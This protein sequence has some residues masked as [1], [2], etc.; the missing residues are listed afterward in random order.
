M[1]FFDICLVFFFSNFLLVSFLFWAITFLG[2]F[3]YEKKE[4]LNQ[5]EFYEC[6]F[7]SINNINF[8]LN[9]GIFITMVFVILYDVEI[10]FL[11]PFLLNNLSLDFFN[12]LNILFLYLCIL[13]TFIID[14]YSGTIKWE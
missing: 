9:L 4:N 13:Y 3:F 2:S 8:S 1:V 6:G 10:L 12:L 14:L 5:N 11:V 7:K